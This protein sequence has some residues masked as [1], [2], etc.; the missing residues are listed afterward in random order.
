MS[1]SAFQ[2]LVIP[3]RKLD[4]EY[5]YCLFLREDNNI[6]QA[7]A[8]GGEENESLLDAASREFEEETGIGN[9]SYIQ[10][11]S[12]CYMPS[13]AVRKEFLEDDIVVI[14]EYSFAVEVNNKRIKLSSEHTRFEWLNYEEA[15]DQL[16]WDSNK[17]ALWEL[18]YKLKN[19]L[20]KKEG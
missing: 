6:W 18:D 11:Q 4:N 5:Q 12:M 9:G 15:I 3:F 17:T 19:N 7:V 8:G 13:I 10:L 16:H 20:L 1:R 14:P 2:V